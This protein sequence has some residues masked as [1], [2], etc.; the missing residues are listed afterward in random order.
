MLWALSALLEQLLFCFK[1]TTTKD[2]H[3]AQKD[4]H[5][6]RNTHFSARTQYHTCTTTYTSWLVPIVSLKSLTAASSSHQ[7]LYLFDNVQGSWYEKQLR[8]LEPHTQCPSSTPS[9]APWVVLLVPR[10]H[11]RIRT[12]PLSTLPR[13]NLA[14]ITFTHLAFLL[15]AT[16]GSNGKPLYLCAPFVNSSLVK[17]SLKTISSVPKYVDPKEW[18]AVN[19]L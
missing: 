7:A 3:L 1:T 2:S 19:P 17:G 16:L 12:C 13:S 6:R 4:A 14:T 18:I 15:S 5:K 9:A 8:K 11:L 10:N